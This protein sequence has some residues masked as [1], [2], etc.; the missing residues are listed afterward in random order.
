MEFTK[1]GTSNL[2]FQHILQLVRVHEYWGKTS[3]VNSDAFYTSHQ[4]NTEHLNIK[5]KT[6]SKET[7]LQVTLYSKNRKQ[8]YV[9]FSS[10]LYSKLNMVKRHVQLKTPTQAIACQA[11][12]IGK[13]STKTVHPTQMVKSCHVC[14]LPS[15]NDRLVHKYTH[16]T[17]FQ[18]IYSPVCFK[19][20]AIL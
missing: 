14:S 5:N 8:L 19:K 4:V 11:S 2:T 7:L 20:E 3:L 13:H 12:E 16:T 6:I 15:E 1:L 17:V 9:F 18:L 10:G